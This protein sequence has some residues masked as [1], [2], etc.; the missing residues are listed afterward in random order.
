MYDDAVAAFLKERQ[1]GDN[2]ELEAALADA[3]Q[4]KGLTPAGP[5][6]TK[7]AAQFKDRE[8]NR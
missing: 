2:Q 3:Y 7:Q 4:A 1:N 5:G 6:S 8:A